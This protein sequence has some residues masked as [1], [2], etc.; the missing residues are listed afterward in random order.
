M[1]AAAI[2]AF[3]ATT[4]LGQTFEVTSVKVN[5]ESRRDRH[6]EFG[7]APNGRFVSLG[8]YLSS[9]ILFAYNL[10]PFQVPE[11]PKLASDPDAIFDIEAKAAGPVSEDQCRL[12]VR[13]LFAD[14]FKM[15]ARL[16][17]R[18]LP[19]YALVVA[20]NGPK[21]QKVTAS[22]TQS[23]VKITINGSFQNPQNLVPADGKPVLGMS[24]A[25]LAQ[26]LGGMPFMEHP[27]VDRTGLEG[28]YKVTLDFNVKF[29]NAPPSDTPDMFNAVEPQLGLKL[30]ERKEP[31]DV[32]V[33]NHLERPDSN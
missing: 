13:A 17:K 14:R 25:R 4:L 29:P 30:E 6:T 11:W 26:L 32:L 12:M 5:T 16:E 2:L 24:M 8:Q 1:R 15:D 7:C 22:D 27:V 23:G 19:V 21:M 31:I 20:K 33:I 3:A 9:A 18:E 28:L 10:K